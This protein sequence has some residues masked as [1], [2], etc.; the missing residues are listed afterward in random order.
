MLEDG[1]IHRDSAEHQESEEH[2]VDLSDGSGE[3]EEEEE[4]EEEDGDDG[5]GWITPSNIKQVQMETGHWTSLAD[6]KVGCL[7]R[8]EEHT[9]EL[10]SR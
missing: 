2:S 1:G 8:S 6:V 3:E 10:Q 5:G 9:S 4:E 7:T